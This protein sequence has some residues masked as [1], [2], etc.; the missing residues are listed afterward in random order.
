M[1]GTEIV[2]LGEDFRSDVDGHDG[3]D[4]A[5]ILVVCYPA[6]VVDLSAEVVQHLVGHDLVLI[7]QH[8]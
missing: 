5:D 2:I 7:Q 4:E 6:A 1:T 8:S 3:F